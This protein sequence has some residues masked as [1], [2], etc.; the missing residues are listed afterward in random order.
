MET[1]KQHKQ[2]GED[3][4]LCTWILNCLLT[5]FTGGGGN[6]FGPSLN[7]YTSSIVTAFREAG[8]SDIILQLA[9]VYTT[10]EQATRQ[11]SNRTN[12]GRSTWFDSLISMRISRRWPS[13]D[14]EGLIALHAQSKHTNRRSTYSIKAQQNEALNIHCHKQPP[15]RKSRT[16]AGQC[17]IECKTTTRKN[18]STSLPATNTM[19]EQH[20][21]ASIL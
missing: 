13:K 7:K 21:A 16:K 4:N 10:L 15:K 18:N 3:K 14:S 19:K 2:E 17:E 5:F 8:D 12:T 1:W 9:C 6:L 11:L 20:T